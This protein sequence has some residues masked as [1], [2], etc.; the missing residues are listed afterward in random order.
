[1]DAGAWRRVAR[2]LG[3]LPPLFTSDEPW[4]DVCLGVESLRAAFVRTTH[5]RTLPVDARQAGSLDR[6]DVSHTS[7]WQVCGGGEGPWLAAHAL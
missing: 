3:P 7:S 1:M 5:W 4:L 2:L 6:V